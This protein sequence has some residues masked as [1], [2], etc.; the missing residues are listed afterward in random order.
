MVRHEGSS[1]LD[2]P[3]VDDFEHHRHGLLRRN[4]TLEIRSY[5][6]EE[7]DHLLVLLEILGSS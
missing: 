3:V 1:V 7:D 2:S 6:L 5:G 4:G